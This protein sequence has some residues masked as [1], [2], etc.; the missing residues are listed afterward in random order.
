M[1]MVTS[2]VSRTGAAPRVVGKHTPGHENEPS[3]SPLRAPRP[4]VACVHAPAPTTAKGL[5]AT[6]NRFEPRKVFVTGSHIPQRVDP[7][8]GLPQTISPLKI[9]GRPQLDS[10]GRQYDLN[11]AL[12]ELDPSF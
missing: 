11:A 12:R 3:R 10:T 1:R 2:V 9:Y 7:V 4:I 6:A 5:Q 8:S